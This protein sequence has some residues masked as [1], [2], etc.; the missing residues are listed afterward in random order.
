MKKKAF[1]IAAAGALTLS[2]IAVTNAGTTGRGITKAGDKHSTHSAESM[3]EI[4]F[5]W[6]DPTKDGYKPYW[7]CSECCSSNPAT[8][9]YKF[10]DKTTKVSESDITLSARSAVD[11]AKITN[12]GITIVD[13][14]SYVGL[15]QAAKSAAYIS[16]SSKNA[17]YFSRSRKQVE[18][19]N[20]GFEAVDYSSFGFIP[21]VADG[22]TSL[23]FSYR[24]KNWSTAKK[25]EGDAAYAV[26]C[27]FAYSADST[28]TTKDYNLDNILFN[29]DT[30]HEVTITAKQAVGS[31]SI[32]GFTKL[33]FNFA[34]LQGYIMISGL[35]YSSVATDKTR[36]VN[37]VAFGT[38][39]TSDVDSAITD[40]SIVNDDIAVYTN[41]SCT[42]MAI[43]EASLADTKKVYVKVPLTFHTITTAGRVAQETAVG[44]LNMDV[45]L[46]EDL[47]SGTNVTVS[48]K[49]YKAGTWFY[50]YMTGNFIDSASTSYGSAGYSSNMD[51]AIRAS[52]IYALVT[53]DFTSAD[54][55]SLQNA[56]NVFSISTKWSAYSTSMAGFADSVKPVYSVLGT[57]N[58][59]AILET[60]Q[61]VPD[62][63]DTT[64]KADGKAI[65]VPVWSYRNLDVSGVSGD[66]QL[67][68]Y[69][70][71]GNG[72]WIG[73]RS[74]QNP[75]NTG[76]WWNY[77]NKSA[78]ANV[79][80]YKNKGKKCNVY[81]FTGYSTDSFYV[82]VAS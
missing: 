43:G 71:S 17:I 25:G 36:V 26:K 76:E 66:N 38:V 35:S 45:L 67:K 39:T 16:D 62:I 57:F 64:T 24:Y 42:T 73:C 48:L 7:R 46:N 28:E 31:D 20:G 59:W 68:V 53:L 65:D 21:T 5:D 8:S 55:Y 63:D 61:M 80:E 6:R 3:S 51:T 40:C 13:T 34:D 74:V 58:G 10:E 78:N 72:T 2:L 4:G 15:D 82:G 1:V 56:A 50:K 27:T 81:Y 54:S 77:D 14:D 69:S 32:S 52:G 9:R 18:S 19:G 29:D 41:E 47:R 12:D 23:T 75:G 79:S 30:W 11:S 37:K 33:A 70:N 44:R 22:A 60:Y 49:G